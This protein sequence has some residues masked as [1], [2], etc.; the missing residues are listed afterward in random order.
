[1]SQKVSMSAKEVQE[2]LAELGV[3][4]TLRTVQQWLDSGYL[5]GIKAGGRWRVK[6]A[7]LAA[8]LETWGL[9]DGRDAAQ[10]P[11]LRD[12]VSP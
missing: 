6:T 4:V 7:A 11:D 1:M 2:R 5:V 9:H 8:L 3:P 12:Q 10:E